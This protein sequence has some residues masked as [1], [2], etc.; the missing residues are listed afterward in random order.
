L[1]TLQ[2]L[3]NELPFSHRY[4]AAH[5]FAVAQCRLTVGP[6]EARVARGDVRPIV[7]IRTSDGPPLAGP[8]IRRGVADGTRTNR[9][10]LNLSATGRQVRVRVDRA[11]TVS[12]FPPRPRSVFLSVDQRRL[13]SGKPLHQVP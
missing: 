10:Q 3:A 9:I 5:E 8:R 7:F 11:G 2:R 12:A 6:A 13:P 4:R 1:P